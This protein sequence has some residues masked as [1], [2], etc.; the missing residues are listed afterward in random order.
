MFLN[1]FVI[2]CCGVAADCIPQTSTEEKQMYLGNANA[3]LCG[4]YK[5]GKF[6]D[7]GIRHVVASS[8]K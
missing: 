2:T 1:I 6:F 7:T 8:R 3:N 4:H 5:A